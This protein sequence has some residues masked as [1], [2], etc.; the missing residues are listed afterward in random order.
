MVEVFRFLPWRSDGRPATEI[1]CSGWPPPPPPR[2]SRRHPEYPLYTRTDGHTDGRSFGSLL[3]FSSSLP[4]LR[5]L[6]KCILSQAAPDFPDVRTSVRIFARGLASHLTLVSL[7]RPQPSRISACV[8]RSNRESA[9]LHWLF[10]CRS[11]VASG[12]SEEH[13]LRR[14]EK[15]RL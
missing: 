1:I 5:G 6:L 8:N 3:L 9:K 7:P 2:A 15:D 4:S 14:N 11:K 13:S 12:H 10:P